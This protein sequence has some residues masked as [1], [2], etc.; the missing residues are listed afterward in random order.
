MKNIFE[1]LTDLLKR[2]ERLV[3]QDGALLKNQTQELAHKSAIFKIK[4]FIPVSIKQNLKD[5]R[6]KVIE[7]FCNILEPIIGGY[8]TFHVRPMYADGVLIDSE[9]VSGDYSEYAI[10]M[11][12]PVIKKNNFTVETLKLYKKYFHNALIVLSTWEGEDES[13]LN[14]ARMLKIEVLLNKKPENFGPVNIN[15]QLTSAKSGITYADGK[16]KKYT[17]KTR[18]DERMYKYNFLIFLSNLL[19]NFPLIQPNS[20]QKG[21]LIGAV[22]SK[23]KL[24]YF[25]DRLIFGYTEDV[26]LY[27]G[28]NLVSDNAVIKLGD[29]SVPFVAEQYLFTEFLKKIN[30]KFEY[31]PEDSLRAQ[32]KHCIVMGEATLDWYW[33]KYRR[34]LEYRVP[35]YRQKNYYLGFPEWLNLYNSYKEENLL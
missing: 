5:F 23:R 3:S 10:V 19:K 18:T 21:R 31:T 24:Y 12:G 2:D 7:L 13:C 1:K 33:L 35:T 8:L 15:L 34:F 26:L 16:K 4:E 22:S 27:F 32:A 14:Q 29:F 9:E 17:L 28:A 20:Q 25:T 30:Y 6:Y 11:Q